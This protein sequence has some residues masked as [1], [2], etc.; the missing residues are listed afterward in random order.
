MVRWFRLNAVST[1]LIKI[2]TLNTLYSSTIV[3]L[4]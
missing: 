3:L 2:T 4:A 1:T